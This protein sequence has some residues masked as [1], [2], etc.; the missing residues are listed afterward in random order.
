MKHGF[1]CGSYEWMKEGISTSAVKG[2]PCLS[3]SD[4]VL[5]LSLAPLLYTFTGVEP[6]RTCTSSLEAMRSNVSNN[7]SLGA[8]LSALMYHHIT[9][10]RR[11][12]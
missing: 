6:S 7:W 3:Y 1:S 10:Y 2:S 11:E 4:L 8:D 9:M 12:K 5:E